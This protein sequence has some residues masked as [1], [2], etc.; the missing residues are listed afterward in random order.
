MTP[1]QTAA[2]VL[3]YVY[4]IGDVQTVGNRI[5]LAHQFDMTANELRDRAAYH[6]QAAGVTAIARTIKALPYVEVIVRA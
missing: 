2:D 3:R 4:G 5:R 6:C 1:F